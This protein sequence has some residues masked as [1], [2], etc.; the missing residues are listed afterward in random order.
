V[1]A[2]RGRR[3]CRSC[4]LRLSNAEN[5][6][7]GP[8]SALPRASAPGIPLGGSVPLQWKLPLPMTALLAA[9]LAAMLAFTYV[10]LRT[11][12]E[13]IVRTRLGSAA[14]QVASS[15]AGSMAQRAE[16]MRMV[17]RE[18]A[19]ARVL[20]A[21]RAGRAPEDAD[22]RAVR[23]PPRGIHRRVIDDLIRQAGIAVHAGTT[24]SMQR[25]QRQNTGAQ[26]L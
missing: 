24:G 13:T 3:D 8:S 21:R 14:A 26:R 18:G 2:G 19:A 20:R 7:R 17:A 4:A 12:A 25:P 11:R 23:G 16:A 9:A 6:M 10:T 1:D 5:L 15:A 22:L